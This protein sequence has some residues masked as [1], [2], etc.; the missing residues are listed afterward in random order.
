MCE[1]AHKTGREPGGRGV[2]GRMNIRE[3]GEE[4]LNGDPGLKT[5]E[6]S[7]EAEVLA[8]P[9]GE[10]GLVRVAT[11]VK[12]FGVVKDGGVIIGSRIEHD[13]LLTFFDGFAVHLDIL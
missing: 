7:T 4:G 9:E 1:A 2:R 12:A 6:G 11:D 10:G 5:S 3:S 13:D 8:G